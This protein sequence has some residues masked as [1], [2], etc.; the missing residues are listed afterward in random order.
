MRPEK[1]KQI[2]GPNA[3]GD[4]FDH[5]QSDTAIAP[6]QNHC[7]HGDPAFFFSIEQT[8]GPHH[9]LLRIAQD[10]KR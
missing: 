5:D 1:R 3:R 6:E 9:F 10:W 2:G 7:R 4:P 8:P